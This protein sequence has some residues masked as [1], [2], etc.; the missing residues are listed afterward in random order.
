MTDYRLEKRLYHALIKQEV[1]KYQRESKRLNEI[2]L[3]KDDLRTTLD[4]IASASGNVELQADKWFNLLK[5]DGLIVNLGEDRFRTLLFDIAVRSSDVRVQHQG[6]KYVLESQLRI[7]ERPMLYPDYLCFDNT[8]NRELYDKLKRLLDEKTGGKGEQLI[9]ALK[10]SGVTGL[11][12]FQYDAMIRLMSTD[13]DALIDAPTAF[14]K[15]YVFLIPV[16]EEAIKHAYENRKGPVAILFYPR[17]TLGSDQMGRLIKTVYH[18]N[19][20]LGLNITIAID[21]GDYE[22]YSED[23]AEFR[24][25]HC[26]LEPPDEY[27][28]LIVSRGQIM[29]KKGQHK[30]PFVKVKRD[31]IHSSPPTIL[32]TNVWAFQYRLLNKNLWGEYLSKD[33]QY[34]VFDEVH[35]Y[36]SIVAGLV[37][38]LLKIFKELVGK[39]RIIFS[40]ATIPPSYLNNM[41]GEDAKNI[42]HLKYVEKRHG[43]D[44]SKLE[45]FLMVG[46]SPEGSWETYLNELVVSLLTIR[47]LSKRAIQSL[48][49][50][51][52]VKEIN[53]VDNQVNEAIKLGSPKDRFDS[54]VD[55][56]D[57]YSLWVYDPSYKLQKSELEHFKK[58]T[59][60]RENIQKDHETHYS[61][62]ANRE[63]IEL[64][65]KNN[66]LGAVFC[67]STLELGVD[68]SKVGIV[69]NAGIPFT[70]DSIIQRVGRA[71]RDK[72]TVNACLSIIIVRN[73]PIEH[74]YLYKGLER[75]IDR[76][77][78]EIPVAFDNV[79]VNA[80]AALLFTAA[81]LAKENHDLKGIG[82]LELI[83]ERTKCDLNSVIKAIELKADVSDI[84]DRLSKAVELAK[85]PEIPKLAQEVSAKK[86]LDDI[87]NR[88][89]QLKQEIQKGLNEASD[90]ILKSAAKRHE[91]KIKESISGVQA[92]L[93]EINPDNKWLN[94]LY[95]ELTNLLDSLKEVYAQSAQEFKS[96]VVN[97]RKVVNELDNDLYELPNSVCGGAQLTLQGGGGAD[98]DQRSLIMVANELYNMKDSHVIRLLETLI[99][100]HYMGNE[101]IDHE[102]YVNYGAGP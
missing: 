80:Y 94:Q 92:V 74:F 77:I 43:R 39:P 84:I 86:S 33:I 102:V 59:E 27:N 4:I 76:E 47:R 99:G 2:Y 50:I 82:G 16:L 57:P 66:K 96:K 36:R 24:G 40:T 13:R 69:V 9:E 10:R 14:G 65:I 46:I 26:P 62:K 79:F 58:I 91:N 101:F 97:W 93:K 23:G 25:I 78:A 72:E 95:H 75:L 42:E 22:K 8:G 53:K 17:K 34:L 63:D 18:V 98:E 29:C 45:L 49:F 71:G 85:S 48:T 55:A 12:R 7:R 70:Q 81:K 67:S 90:I 28:P 88:C 5:D 6:T 3:T 15:T 61:E 19:Q 32:I 64:G 83:F 56:L 30:F 54:S 89:Q 100:F 11:S 41:L 38:Y 20:I 73:N 31:E 1:D 37:R 51:D 68:Y 87:N 44:D 21:D 60:L 52:N 35:A